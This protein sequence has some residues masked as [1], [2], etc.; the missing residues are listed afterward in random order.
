MRNVYNLISD[1]FKDMGLDETRYIVNVD[2]NKITIKDSS[3]FESTIE[4]NMDGE[5]LKDFD[6]TNNLFS[7]LAW[8]RFCRVFEREVT[9]PDA[10]YA[11][12]GALANQ[13]NRFGTNAWMT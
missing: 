4:L 2:N 10:F 7:N 5:T 3:Q 12:L 8:N 9:Y 6:D 13:A 11:F 1:G